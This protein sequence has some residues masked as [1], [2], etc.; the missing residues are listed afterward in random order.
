M[1]YQWRSIVRW[2]TD[3]VPHPVRRKS[4]T[5]HGTVQDGARGLGTHAGSGMQL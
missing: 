5:L 3:A 4:H 2:I 1:S